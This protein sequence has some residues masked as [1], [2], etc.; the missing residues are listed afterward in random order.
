MNGAQT[1]ALHQRADATNDKR[2]DD[3][4]RPEAD[5]LSGLI[6]EIGAQHVE[7][8]MGKVEYAHHAKDER[9][10]TRQHEQ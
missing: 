7:A 1:V 4:C 10:A 8:G 3:Q 2:C 9:K 5:P 6:R